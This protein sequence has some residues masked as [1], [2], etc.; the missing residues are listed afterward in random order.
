MFM[1]RLRSLVPL[2][3]RQSTAARRP[4]ARRRSRLTLETLEE[5][6][7]PAVYNVTGLADGV[8][9]VTPVSTGVFNASTLCA[10]ISAANANPGR[11]TINLSV[12]GT[13]RSP[14][15]DARR[16]RQRRRRIRHPAHR[17]Q[18][19]HPEHQRRHRRRRRQ[20]P[21]PRLRHQPHRQ[22][23]TPTHQ[24]TVTFA[25]L[26]HRQRP[27]P[28]RRRRGRQRRRHPRPGQRQPDAQQRG[29]HRQHRHRRRRRH[30]HGEHG[31]STPW[32]LTI[33]SSTISNNHAGDAGGGIETDG[34]GHVNI[35]AGTVITGNTGVNQGAGIWLDAIN[36]A[37][38]GS[39]TITNPGIRATPR[40][41]TV[42][43]TPVDG[44]DAG[45]RASRPSTWPA[46]PV[47]GVTITN[48]GSGYD[49]PPTISFSAPA[50]RRRLHRHD[51]AV[52]D[53]P[54]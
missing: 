51:L 7:A 10:A 30:R 3:F 41:P 52:P 22:P 44:V 47:V 6:L 23:T 24:F 15:R 4:T 46:T 50:P 43:F 39:V 13:T 33:N 16:S 2:R 17:R 19:D 48:P 5:R 25:G 26:H 20:P 18:P 27:G 53:V 42:T 38:V 12:A 1:N 11:N 32:T 40:P 31:G 14:C 54:R 9:T 37:R 35:N 21:R 49:M 36:G 45:P 34:S 8:G 28:A 29:R